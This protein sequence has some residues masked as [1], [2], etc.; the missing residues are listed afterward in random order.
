VDSE[1]NENEPPEKKHFEV[2]RTNYPGFKHF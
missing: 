1:T 2:S